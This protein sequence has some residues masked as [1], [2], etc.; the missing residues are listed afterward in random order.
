MILQPRKKGYIDKKIRFK[1]RNKY[2]ANESAAKF[3]RK[4]K[5]RII[6]DQILIYSNR[7][8]RYYRWHLSFIITERIIEGTNESF[9][10]RPMN[11]TTRYSRHRRRLIKP[12]FL[13]VNG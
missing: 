5:Y 2:I 10:S 7:E 11:E 3:K 13:R 12:S 4:K 1:R 9:S 6:T 8:L